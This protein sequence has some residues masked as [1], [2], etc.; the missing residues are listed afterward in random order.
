[1]AELRG[2]VIGA[3]YFSAFHL[4]AWDRLPGVT[5]TAL[6]DTDRG[7]GRG[8]AEE[9]DIPRCYPD[10]REMLGREKPDFVDVITP[11]ET[12]RDIVRAAAEAGVHVICQKPL[13]PDFAEAQA[14]VADARA[15]GIRLMAHENFRF[16][17]WHREI[18]KL[19]GAG[20]LG[21]I[22]TLSVRTRLG[23]GAGPDAYRERQPYFRTMARFLLHETGV[24]FVD[25]FRFLL[26]EV[27]RVD[28]RLR[29]L[30]PVLAG[31]DTAHLVCEFAGGA[32]GVWDA[33]RTSPSPA[34]D[35]RYT[36]GEF[37]V[38]GDKGSL[39]LRT[40]G[41][42]TLQKVGEQELLY[43]YRPPHRGFA[44]D[45]V[46]A[47]QKHFLE[48]LRDGGRFETEGDEYLRT[49]AVVE[50]AYASARTGQAVRVEYPPHPVSG[51]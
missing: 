39:H 14:L 49:L 48:R 6:S 18:K 1:M 47:T 23:D 22:H 16:Q 45:C 10:Y 43:P 15:G 26:G 51:A 46:L 7:R 9:F 42:M 17:P 4:E 8:R 44:G 29:Q 12:H 27:E 2:V 19:V 25:V 38:E 5:V 34:E 35:P 11:P 13:A 24:H 32:L 40:D 21:R 36:F 31:E 20:A 3:G 28:C 33:N 50:A 37:L 30:N 41:S